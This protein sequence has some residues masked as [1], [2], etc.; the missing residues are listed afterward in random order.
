M[1]DSE[2]AELVRIVERLGRPETI[3]AMVNFKKAAVAF[4]N[5]AG[6]P[7]ET[8][9]AKVWAMGCAMRKA[10]RGCE[11]MGKRRPYLHNAAYKMFVDTV[12]MVL[13]NNLLSVEQVDDAV[14]FAV[15]RY[16]AERRGLIN[17]D[18]DRLHASAL[19][20]RVDGQKMVKNGTS[21]GET[22]NGKDAVNHDES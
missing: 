5:A 14:A 4:G 8:L 9:A 13:R 6:V 21:V 18:D 2:R 16:D 19:G 17:K 12:V 10:G 3:E 20:L 1:T 22:E 15:D 7:V 11:W